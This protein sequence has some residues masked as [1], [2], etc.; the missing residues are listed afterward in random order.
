MN[1]TETARLLSKAALIDAR[2]VDQP[3]VAAWQE[4]LA[5][6]E[7]RLAL[8]ALT[9]HRR[10]S[11]EWVTPAHIIAGV[12]KVKAARSAQAR[13]ASAIESARRPA[14]EGRRGDPMPAKLREMLSGFAD[15]TRIPD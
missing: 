11:T 1:L 7:Y 12:R 9:L 5:D 8:E 6:V 3:T 14:L 10:E 4:V 13:R 15:R 2:T